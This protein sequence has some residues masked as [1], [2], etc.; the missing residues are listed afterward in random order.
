MD[1]VVPV[2]MVGAGGNEL[3]VTVFG[4]EVPELHPFVITCT[5]NVPEELT[6]IDCVVAPLDQKLFVA[7]DEV[8]VTDPPAQKVVGPPAVIVGTDGMV[9]T[10]T[11][12]GAEAGDVQPN[13][14]WVTVYEPLAVTVMDCVVS[15]VDQVFPELAEDVKTTEL[16]AQN[17]VGPPA[18]T[19]GAAGIGFTVTV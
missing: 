16:P 3:T 13:K 2:T 7:E 18:V 4:A 5:R 14:V 19:F 10:M 6:V 11:L 12:T 9:F 1:S 15:V 17:V 8:N